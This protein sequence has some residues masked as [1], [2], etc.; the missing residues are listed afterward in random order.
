[1]NNVFTNCKQF[2]SQ[3][4]GEWNPSDGHWHGLDFRWNG[5]VY[6]FQTDS[7]FNAENTILPDGRKARFGVYILHN[8]SYKLIG[9]FATPQEA[10][11]KCVIENKLLGDIIVAE[12]TEML[13]QD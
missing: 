9:E 7:M 1:M 12:E 4:T 13:G 3:Y 5:K 8:S 11:E 10:L 6:R 2:L